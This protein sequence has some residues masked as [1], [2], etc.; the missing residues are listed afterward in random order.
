MTE[1]KRFGD[2]SY[3]MAALADAL[4]QD[5][6]EADADSLID[7]A[8]RVELLS[9][10]LQNC[11]GGPFNGQ[12]GR[13]RL[14][15]EI[16][17]RVH[18]DIVIETGTFRGIT[19][20]W[21]ATNFSGPVLSCEIERLYLIQARHRLR[22]LDNVSLFQADSCT[23]LR[24][25]I[26]EFP[27]SSRVLFYLD[28]HWKDDLPLVDELRIIV[29]SGL[30]FVVII[31]DFKVPLDKGYNFDDYGPGKALKLELLDFLQDTCQFFFPRLHASEETGAVSGSCVLASGLAGE[32]TGCSLLRGGSWR[33]WKMAELQD[34]YYPLLK[35]RMEE[36]STK[37]DKL[38]E[39]CNEQGE[40]GRLL[41]EETGKNLDFERQ[42]RME[43][44]SAKLD[45]LLERRNEQGDLGRLLVEERAKNLDLQ[46]QIYRAEHG[47]DE[48]RRELRELL[49][50]GQQA[51]GE[52]VVAL[53]SEAAAR[54]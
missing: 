33:E 35:E 38:L 45:K 10:E 1:G 3:V 32:I 26:A 2:V 27:K 43:E 13:Q 4:R 28:A 46:R 14:V 37:L 19:T 15:L 9:D 24:E 31:D 23:F 39:R 5:G 18:P 49:E 42:E 47:S 7:A 40:L 54:C 29:G 36:W 12:T 50:Q 52:L 6:K 34:E 20:E 16:L 22:R 17:E 21:F 41:A 11:W 8:A 25:R 44:W 51:V 53:H 30:Q 48:R